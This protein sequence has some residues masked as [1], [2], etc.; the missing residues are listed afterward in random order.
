MAGDRGGPSVDHRDDRCTCRSRSSPSC[1]WTAARPPRRRVAQ[2]LGDLA[3]SSSLTSDPRSPVTSADGKRRAALGDEVNGVR[4]ARSNSN[5]GA[6]GEY[7]EV[8]DP[9]HGQWNVTPH[10]DVADSQLLK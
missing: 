9:T 2:A 1:R 3:R 4:V 7:L 6:V 8:P 10:Q 5:N